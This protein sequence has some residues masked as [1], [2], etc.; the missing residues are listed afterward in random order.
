MIPRHTAAKLLTWAAANDNREVTEA[1]ATAWAAALHEHVT[2]DDGMAA[3]SAHYASD[4]RWIMPAQINAHVTAIRR[5]RLTRMAT[6][7]PPEALDGNPCREIAWQRAYR[8]AFA[9]TGNHDQAQSAACTAVGIP[10]PAPVITAPRPPEL[11]A[12]TAGARCEHACLTAPTTAK[13]R[14]A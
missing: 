8:A 3:I 10:T 1:A 14:A 12:L 6:P 9:D 4:P 2:L 13:E 5:E 7:Q 11:S